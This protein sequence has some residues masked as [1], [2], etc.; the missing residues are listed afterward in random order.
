MTPWGALA[1]I[2]GILLGVAGA[3]GMTHLILVAFAISERELDT[4]EIILSVLGSI[5]YAG[6]IAL[7]ASMMTFR[8]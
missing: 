5:V 4:W 1:V 6:A 2:A 3:L 8:W 7:S